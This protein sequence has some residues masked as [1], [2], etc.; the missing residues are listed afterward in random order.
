MA[1]RQEELIRESGL[2]MMGVVM[3][4]A[5]AGALA[6]VV[7]WGVWYIFAGFFPKIWGLPRILVDAIGG[8]FYVFVILIYVWLLKDAKED[9]IEH[10]GPGITIRDFAKE[11]PLLSF[12]V[13]FLIID[14]MA[15]VRFSLVAGL[16]G[17]V[18]LAFLFGVWKIIWYL[19]RGL[20]GFLMSVLDRLSFVQ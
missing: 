2:K 6:P 4:L 5:L 10:L 3:L 20:L 11:Y 8:A 7:L 1:G 12:F 14:F 17:F 9:C 16:A 18:A 13:I 15:S 19:F